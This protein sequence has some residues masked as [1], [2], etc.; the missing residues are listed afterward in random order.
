MGYICPVCNGLTTLQAVCSE[1]HHQLD[2][3]GRVDDLW[4]PY[5]PY[6]EIDDIKMSNG[7][8][9]IKEH[10]CIHI[11]T[12]PICGKDHYIPVNEQYQE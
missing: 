2:D 1:C 5:T 7:F 6:R 4:G 8:E 11:A 12:C 3:L 10:Q 9:D